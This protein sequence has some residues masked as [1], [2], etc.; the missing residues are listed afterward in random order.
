VIFGSPGLG[1]WDREDLDVPED[2]LFRIEAR[3]DAV[4][5]LA[6]F[7][8]DPTWLEG[9]EGL[10]AK[11]TEVYDESVGHSEYLIDGTTSQHNMSVTVAGV[12]EQ[13]VSDDGRGAGDVLTWWPEFMR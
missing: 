2:H 3:R 11:E 6:S 8:I 9:V 7:G 1:T 5:D 12:P 13:Q 4:A 10:S